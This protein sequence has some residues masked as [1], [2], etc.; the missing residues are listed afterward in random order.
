MPQYDESA[1]E[2]QIALALAEENQ[3]AQALVR[4]ESLAKKAT[5]PFRQLHL[6]MQAADLKV[7]IGKSDQALHDFETSLAKRSPD[8]RPHREGRRKIEEVFLLNDDQAGLVSYY[9][10]WTKRK[11]MTSR[12]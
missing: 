8:S 7:R 5:H 11:P 3:P 1:V 10:R 12:R 2:E 9:E 6:S 4:F